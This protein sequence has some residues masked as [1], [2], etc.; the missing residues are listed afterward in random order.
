MYQIL[1]III[2]HISDILPFYIFFELINIILKKYIINYN[3]SLIYLY[4]HLFV[5]IINTVILLPFIIL[6]FSNPLLTD[7]FDNNYYIYIYP[8]T[9]GLHILHLVHNFKSINIDEII[10]HIIT[11]IFW[12][13]IY[14]NK[15]IIYIA[16]MITMCGIPGGITYFLLILQKHLIINKITEK[17]ISTYVNIWIRAPFCI[18]FSSLLYI[19]NI[20][21]KY[22]WFNIFCICFTLING[23]HFMHNITENYYMNKYL[24]KIEK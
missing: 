20:N 18:I 10:H 24:K 5:N 17:K 19:H 8:M 1:N 12:Y 7:Y 15:S 3:F 13:N 2:N 22:Y 6:L 9:I 23:I 21:S 11:H 4:L 16:P 14:L